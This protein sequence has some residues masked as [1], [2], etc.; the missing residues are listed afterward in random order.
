[1]LGLLALLAPARLT[2]GVTTGIP[3]IPLVGSSRVATPIGVLTLA[4]VG[5]LAVVTAR[6]WWPVLRA[7]DVPGAVLVAVALGS[8]CSP[9]PRPTPTR[10]RRPLGLVLLPVGAAAVGLYLW[11]ARRAAHPLVPRGVVR[12]RVP[13]ALLV[14]LLVGAALVTVVVDVP[15]LARLTLTG[16]QTTAALVLV[17]FLVAVPVGALLGG[18]LL[19]RLGPGAVAAAGLALAAAGLAVMATW[20]PGSLAAAPATVVLV[21]AGLGTGLAV[22]PVNAV[23]L[24]DAPASAHGVASSLVVV[25]RMVGMVVGLALLTAV[26]L[27]RFSEAVAL[28]P[29]PTDAAALV[30]AGVVQV[31]TVLA[32]GAVAAALAAVLALRLGLR[33]QT[34]QDSRRHAASQDIHS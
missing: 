30:R 28:L 21:L 4:L 3:F 6:R 31:Q 32:G 18:A 22:A 5:V 8:W 12:G 17:R 9:S 33:P 13:V 14:S 16:S 23:A 10:G 24:A 34:G 11:H 27:R 7:A 20:G 1:M 15:L 19:R 26:G 29:D 25:A 2:T